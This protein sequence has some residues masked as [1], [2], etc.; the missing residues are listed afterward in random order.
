MANQRKGIPPGWTWRDG[1][2]RWVPS[3]TLRQAGWKGLDLKDERGAYL[4]RG[5]SIDRA[6]AIAAAVDGWRKGRA[7][8]AAFVDIAPQGAAMAR[9]VSATD[10][11]AIGAL[12]DAYLAS[13]EF[14]GLAVKT[15]ED[16]RS[17]LSRMIDVLAGHP[18]KPRPDAAPEALAAYR[19][20]R[21]RVRALSIMVLEPPP[22][23][24]AASADEAAGPLYTVYWKLREHAGPHMAH[25][26]L[27]NISA[28]LEWCFRRRAIPA[29]W[30]QLVDRETP[31]GRIRV[32]TWDELAA[33]IA[34]AEAAGLPSIADAIILGVDLSWSQCDR[35]SLRWSQVDGLGRVKGARQKTGRKGET[36]TL[37]GLA[38]ARLP[39]IKAR[40]RE[41]WGENVAMTH[42][43]VCELTGRPWKADH[44]RH[45]FAEI[46]EAA[47]AK[48]PTVAD[49]RDQD[50]RDT[51]ITVAFQAG[52]TPAE[53]ASRSLH[54]LKRIHD[55]LDKHY[56]EIGQ[57]IAD[58]GADKLN[59][60]LASKG[61]AI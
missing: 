49:F 59:A 9:P 45:K 32:G 12:L 4:A 39:L 46:R 3:P 24:E 44:Y 18:A 34:A 27:A 30:A 8:P 55:V 7:V 21:E 25:G 28:W 42:V 47:A 35:L 53:I 17:K 1:R 36:P 6:E 19:A 51:A 41:T 11:R 26:A 15:Q 61:V 5:A 50:L 48:C 22:F 33:L 20:A 16:R 57:E 14:T 10:R 23:D 58:A 40:Q 13:R 29:N 37:T 54:S 56:V 52:L 31:P 43:L 60:Y 2:P 38:G